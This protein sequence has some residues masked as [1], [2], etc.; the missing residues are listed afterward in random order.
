MA[1]KRTPL[2]IELEQTHDCY[3]VNCTD[4][5][6]HTT[7]KWLATIGMDKDTVSN[8]MEVRT[9][10][11][12]PVLERM[13]KDPLVK[14]IQLVYVGKDSAQMI[15]R[16][17]RKHSTAK[18]LVKSGTMWLGEQSSG[19]VD[20]VTMMAPSEKNWQAFLSSVEGIYDIKLK[21]KRY[22]RPKE[23]VSFDVFRSSGFMNLK[24]ANELLTDRQMEAFNTACQLGYYE[25]PKK[26]DIAEIAL[27]LGV[28]PG[29]AAELLRHA[30]RKLL[31]IL[32]DILRMMR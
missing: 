10:E 7:V 23:S 31:P 26:T 30:E 5:A 3:T 24:A 25:T 16:S 6:H 2:I 14:Q 11:L 29:T 19:G 20:Y 13:R 21:A 32:S 28:A 12:K 1:E 27:K 9:D 4:K 8:L 22:L 18:H 15:V 17:S